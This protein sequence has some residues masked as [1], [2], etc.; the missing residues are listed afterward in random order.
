MLPSPDS[1]GLLNPACPDLS[2]IH[3]ERAGVKSPDQIPKPYPKSH[4]NPVL[5]KIYSLSIFY[6]LSSTFLFNSLDSLTNRYYTV[7]G[8]IPDNN[9]AGN[10]IMNAD[11]CQYSYDYENRLADILDDANDPLAEFNDD[12]LG[13]RIQKDDHVAVEKTRYYHNHNWQVL[14][15]YNDSGALLCS[16]R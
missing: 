10:L 15:E 9:Y 2:G 7:G 13:R 4:S 11:N 12:A 14:A 8:N 16:Y 1:S 5:D 3:R 6:L